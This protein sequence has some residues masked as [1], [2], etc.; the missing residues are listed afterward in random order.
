MIFSFFAEQL[1]DQSEG[2]LAPHV[3][4]FNEVCANEDP[5]TYEKLIQVLPPKVL[6]VETK[7][8]NT[9]LGKS[10]QDTGR[11]GS[12]EKP[13]LPNNNGSGDAPSSDRHTVTTAGR[14]NTS[15]SGRSTHS[16][17]KQG[18]SSVKRF[19]FPPM[20]VYFVQED[21]NNNDSEYELELVRLEYP[22]HLL[23]TR[24]FRKL[25]DWNDGDSNNGANREEEGV[26]R[27]YFG[28]VCTVDGKPV[29][30]STAI[31][32]DDFRSSGGAGGDGMV[33][34]LLQISEPWEDN[35]PEDND[36]NDD[37]DPLELRYGPQCN[38]TTNI[39]ILINFA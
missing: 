15:L 29:L 21:N 5:V 39:T 12:V 9:S 17:N 34:P 31:L 13:T 7:L 6:D 4:L 25:I 22:P 19:L 1:G 30:E 10:K 36:L 2:I 11:A 33:S 35:Y 18:G 26:Y 23:S 32:Q 24:R 27:E 20:P 37:D 8:A 38:L 28:K 14:R 16:T 3:E